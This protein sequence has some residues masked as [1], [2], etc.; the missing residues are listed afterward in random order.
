MTHIKKYT[1]WLVFIHCLYTGESQAVSSKSNPVVWEEYLSF[2]SAGLLTAGVLLYNLITT[3]RDMN[4]QIGNQTRAQAALK[5]SHNITVYYPCADH[6]NNALQELSNQTQLRVITLQENNTNRCSLILLFAQAIKLSPCIVYIERND[7]LQNF[8]DLPSDKYKPDFLKEM[9]RLQKTDNSV[10]VIGHAKNH[11]LQSI[12]DIFTISFNIKNENPSYQERVE[13]LHILLSQEDTT[14]L[15]IEDIAKQTIAFSYKEIINLIQTT[16]NLSLTQDAPTLHKHHVQQAYNEI[17]TSQTIYKA[18]CINLYKT[19]IH[20]M[21]H[22]LTTTLF[23][24][25]FILHNVTAT[26]QL[27]KSSITMG[28]TQITRKAITYEYESELLPLYE[29]HIMILL[30]GKIAEQIVFGLPNNQELNI[31]NGYA[32]LI[33]NPNGAQNDLYKARNIAQDM[34]DIVRHDLFQQLLYRQ[35]QNILMKNIYAKTLKLI[36]PYKNTIEETARLLEQHEFLPGSQ[37]H[38]IVHGP[39]WSWLF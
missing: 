17:T 29:H 28:S 26:P 7:T 5:D 30:A 22:A 36:L 6:S 31:E 37:I 38:K 23:S 3:P 16:K 1:L 21:G 39:S 9:L 18:Q 12:N 27:E 13:F 2:Q 33:N 24:S 35:D 8:I 20:E 11:N 10:V 34:I 32:D 14:E 15:N 4:F 25:Q 19:S